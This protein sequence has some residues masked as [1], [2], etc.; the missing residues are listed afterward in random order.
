MKNPSL[1]MG[2]ALAA[3]H[4]VAATAGQQPP[5][6][7][8]PASGPSYILPANGATGYA[9]EPK[10]SLQGEAAPQLPASS[11]SNLAAGV[12][13]LLGG[14][15]LGYLPHQPAIHGSLSSLGPT[16]Q[17]QQQQLPYGTS[18]PP[19][20]S[21]AMHGL[22]SGRTSVNAA[23]VSSVAPVVVSMP[24]P[25][26]QEARPLVPAAAALP[27]LGGET[28]TL[29]QPIMSS[30]AQPSG[31]YQ[32][33]GGLIP[34]MMMSGG[35]HLPGLYHHQLA[36]QQQHP[37]Q[38]QQRYILQQQQV[39]GSPV[40]PP[41]LLDHHRLSPSNLSLVQSAG[42]GHLQQQPA[43]QLGAALHQHPAAPM[44][45]HYN[46]FSGY[47]GGLGLQPVLNHHQPV[48]LAGLQSVLGQHPH[49]LTAGSAAALGHHYP[50]SAVLSMGGLPTAGV[51]TA[52]LIGM[53]PQGVPS[54]AAGHQ[55]IS[56]G[57]PAA[58]MTGSYHDEVAGSGL[59]PDKSKQQQQ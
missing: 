11:L 16:S 1:S 35:H 33:P 56:N 28:H 9:L 24:P 39:P 8:L 26:R 53:S 7:G 58:S 4:P 25:V 27:L 18:Y 45:N 49:Q 57:G 14:Y 51:A 20:V 3:P 52:G 29:R 37:G 54:L 50:S 5:A 13:G 15:P 41:P 55:L 17:Q 12:E 38:A 2:E 32:P 6:Y 30:T 22:H 43:Q 59:D 23:P 21:S 42:S 46:T 44:Y 31:T 47:P 19:V 40:S 34:F 36:Q 48:G 10:N